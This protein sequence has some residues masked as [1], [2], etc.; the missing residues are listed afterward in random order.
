M[1]LKIFASILLSTLAAACGGTETNTATNSATNTN[2]ANTAQNTAVAYSTPTQEATTNNAP[3]LAPVVR[4]YYD[5]LK[6]KDSAALKEVLSKDFVQ[7][8]EADMKE[9]KKTN[10][11]A[12]LA[13]TDKIPEKPIEVRNEKIQGDK[14]VAEIR[15]GSYPNWTPLA[16]VK[17]DGKW[18]L[19]NESPAIENVSGK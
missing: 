1:K 3:T 13:E 12:F 19:T 17:E 14:G 15:G 9:E 6:N 10:M 8:I 2:A 18:K 4:G 16:F 7:S 5:A 11:A